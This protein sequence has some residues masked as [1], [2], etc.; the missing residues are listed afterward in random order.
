MASSDEEVSP[1]SRF[2]SV[3]AKKLIE[4]FK[5][6]GNLDVADERISLS[7]ELLA[8]VEQGDL[9]EVEQ[10]LLGNTQYLLHFAIAVD[11]IGVVSYLTRFKPSFLK[12][13]MHIGPPT[14][15]LGGSPLHVAVALQQHH[16]VKVLLSYWK[17]KN[18]YVQMHAD[19]SGSPFVLKGKVSLDKGPHPIALA[20][21]N[22]D[23]EV[24]KLL[25]K[26]KASVKQRYGCQGRTPLEAA[27]V[28][29]SINCQTYFMRNFSGAELDVNSRVFTLALPN[30]DFLALLLHKFPTIDISAE[31]LHHACFAGVEAVRLLLASGRAGVVV[32][33]TCNSLTALMTVAW[34]SHITD[35]DATATARI[36]LDFGA[37]ATVQRA[38]DGSTPLDWANKHQKAELADLLTQ[39]PRTGKR[40]RVTL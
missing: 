10:R 7:S 23:A 36:L 38:A 12:Q 19:H 34:S 5:R 40:R 32:N 4:C 31:N 30:V 29:H 16:T 27:I 28:H 2:P 21:A 26:A 25:I 17:D 9:K 20:V 14:G 11:Q 8:A 13:N 3:S 24:C 35:K 39:L 22:D 18:L 1:E 33:E 6:G 15:Y 37:D